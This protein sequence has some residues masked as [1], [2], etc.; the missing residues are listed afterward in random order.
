MCAV[1]MQTQFTMT[2]K[3]SHMQMIALHSAAIDILGK[4]SI[5]V[6]YH[7]GIP[8]NETIKD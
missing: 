3:Q 5:Y 1:N 2:G 4:C 6:V 8:L 7:F